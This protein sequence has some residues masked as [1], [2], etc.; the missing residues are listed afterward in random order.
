MTQGILEREF[1]RLVT[2]AKSGRY[3]SSEES[4]VQHSDFE[5]IERLIKSAL[6]FGKLRENKT[7]IK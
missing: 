2:L 5:V 6:A 1:E 3:L 4:T 7:E